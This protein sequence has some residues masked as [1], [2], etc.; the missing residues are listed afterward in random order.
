M[1]TVLIVLFISVGITA[2]VPNPRYGHQEAMVKKNVVPDKIG[3][4]TNDFIDFG[5]I[6]MK[7]L[8]RPYQGHSRYQPGIDCSMFTQEVMR[9]YTRKDIG[10][11]VEEQYQ[12]G[13]EVPRNRLIPGDLVFFITERDQ[14]SHVGIYIGFNQFVHASSS[15]GVIISGLSEKYWAH[16]Y[17]SARRIIE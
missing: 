9:E 17:V 1:R 8:G 10:R 15:Q 5:M 13:R 6:I 16:R 4:T 3:R 11:T 14:I 2:C 7:Y 12:K